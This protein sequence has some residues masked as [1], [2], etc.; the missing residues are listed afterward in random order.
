MT[1]RHGQSEAPLVS[2]VIPTYNR[3]D[4]IV[5]TLD[6][7]CAQTYPHWEA[8]VVDDASTDDT[9]AYLEQVSREEPRI[10]PFRREGEVGNANVCRNQGVVHSRGRYLIFLDSDDLLAPDCLERRVQDMERHPELGYIAYLSELFAE[11]P[12][13]LG[14]PWNVF[15]TES[16]LTRF[17]RVDNPW[18]TT[19]PIWRREVTERIPWDTSVLSWQDGDLHMRVLA[20]GIAGGRVNLAD[21]YVRRSPQVADRMS[22]KDSSAPHIR[23]HAR[24]FLA[25]AGLLRDGGDMTDERARLIARVIL[26]KCVSLAVRGHP[27]EALAFWREAAAMR[28]PGALQSIVGHIV[29][30]LWSLPGG[31]LISA[32]C[33]RVRDQW[34]KRRPLDRRTSGEGILSPGP[35]VRS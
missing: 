34:R 25:V 14:I 32:A 29:F 33:R 23:T 3:R 28:L 26:S 8:I 4:L 7:V 12:G 16:D 15:T 6:S 27:C 20:S 22:Q 11:A 18:H 19:G 1:G 5:E 13:D 9:W 10:R 35:R 30:A 17:L 2:V 24:S 31:G 21:N